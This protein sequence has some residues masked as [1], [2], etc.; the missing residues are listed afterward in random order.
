MRSI[1]KLFFVLVLLAAIG[2]AGAWFWAGT[3]PGPVVTIRQ[4]GALVGQA[5]MLDMM[6]EAPGGTLS[7]LEAT[8]EQGD[9]RMSV[10]SQQDGLPS[11]GG[12]ESADRLYV[13]RPI[14][15]RAI[16]ELQSGT[17]RIV[18]TRRA[19]GALWHCAKRPRR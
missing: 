14:G 7:R 4:P 18:V 2:G 6:V 19:A 16:P 1:A 17:A 9:R 12:G 3:L 10:Y 8:L 15:Q 13:M 5:G 11:T